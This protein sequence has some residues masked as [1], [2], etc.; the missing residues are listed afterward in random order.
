[1]NFEISKKIESVKFILSNYV[2]KEFKILLYFF[3]IA[4]IIFSFLE[5]AELVDKGTIQNYDIAILKSLRNPNDL[6]DAI[7]PK[8][9]EVIF[10]D[11]TALGGVAIISLSTILIIGFL[12]LQKKRTTA[13][14]ILVAVIGGT[15]IDLFLKTFYARERPDLA[16]HL[17]EAASKS[18]PSGHS[19]I[20]MTTYLSYAGLLAQIQKNFYVRIYLVSTALLIVFLIGIRRVFLGVHYP[21]DVLGGWLAG[22][23]WALICWYLFHLRK[24]KTE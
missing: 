15:L 13:F 10:R 5:I 6:Q 4:L 7:G 23:A 19:M 3:F 1:M 12:L 22:L 2:F 14:F 18:F 20:S 17:T 8:W 21:S 11:I 9:I 16:F 24:R